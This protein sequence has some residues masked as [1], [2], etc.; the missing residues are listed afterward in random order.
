M[1][2]SSNAAA[3]AALIIIVVVIIAAM[4]YHTGS[5]AQ[6]RTL[7]FSNNA[8][9]ST[10]SDEARN[11]A[12]SLAAVKSRME[13][14]RSLAPKQTDPALLDAAARRKA[15]SIRSRMVAAH[16]QRRQRPLSYDPTETMFISISSFRDLQCA[17]TIYDMYEKAKFP[18]NVYVGAVEQHI[19]GDPSCVPEQYARECT[20]G[21]WCPS[22]NIKTRLINPKDAKGPTFGR[23]YGMLMFRDE[24]Y[25]MMIDSHNRWVTNWDS[26]VITMYKGLPTKKGVLAHY[27][28]AWINPEDKSDKNETNGPLDNRQTT[29]Y[30]CTAHW[31]NELGYVRMGGFIINRKAKF[32]K[33]TCRPQPF[34]GAGFVFALGQMVREVPFDPHLHYV[35]NGEEIMY[36]VRMWTHGWDIFSPSENIL[37]HYYYRSNAKKFWG[38]LPAG[39]DQKRDAAQRRIQ[40]MLKTYKQNT[41]ERFVP[42]DTKEEA[43]LIEA[44]KYGLGKERTLEQYYEFAGIDRVHHTFTRDFCKE[45]S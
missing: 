24:K 30:M 11:L 10:F 18:R 26:I 13:R 12:S 21:D 17:P 14:V 22:D 9:P 29:M 7:F 33:D 32:G 35:F 36:T 3:S 20:G 23:Y 37:Y 16:G 19:P 41:T 28:E 5:F 38:I 1:A 45:Y 42:D 44:D 4:A 2:S 31:L 15:R 6:T 39:W 34:A 27:P 40:W 43:V 25:F 8:G